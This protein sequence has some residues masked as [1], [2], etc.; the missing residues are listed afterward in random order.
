MYILCEYICIYNIYIFCKYFTLEIQ[1]ESENVHGNISKII[2]L[3]LFFFCA[4]RGG[5]REKYNS[6]QSMFRKKICSM[7][8]FKIF[9]ESENILSDRLNQSRKVFFSSTLPILFS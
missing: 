6:C 4:I 1:K 8:A 9:I 7:F 3:K 5:G 2:L